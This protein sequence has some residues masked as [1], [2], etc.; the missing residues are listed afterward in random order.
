M[1]LFTII[2]K[3]LAAISTVGA[4][5]CIAAGFYKPHCFITAAFYVILAVAIFGAMRE[6]KEEDGHHA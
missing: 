1:R 4:A 3:A 6:R 2:E 5:A